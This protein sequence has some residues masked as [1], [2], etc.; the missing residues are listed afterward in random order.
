MKSLMQRNNPPAEFNEWLEKTRALNPL[1]IG[2]RDC[3]DQMIGKFY[4]DKSNALTTA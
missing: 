4:L 1:I 3:G 2:H